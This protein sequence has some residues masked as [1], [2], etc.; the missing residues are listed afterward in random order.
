MRTLIIVGLVGLGVTLTACDPNNDVTENE[1]EQP[2]VTEAEKS[3]HIAEA[4]GVIKQFATTLKSELIGAMKNGGPVNA[5]EV[6]HS[7]APVLAEKIGG[8]YGATLTRVSMKNRN[9]ILG[10][11]NAWQAKVLQDF[12]ARVANGK[13]IE[14]LKYVDIAEVTGGQQFRMMKA[15]PTG[16]ICLTCH[17][18][19][20]APEVQAKLTALYPNDHATGFSAGQ[21]RGAFVY[22][23]PL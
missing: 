10:V 12:E 9:A 3:A 11:P 17:G 1:T 6:C 5:I 22:T 18:E 15:I 23:K 14:T 16:A 4:K 8:E 20:I 13:A 19:S 7:R 21:I 2:A